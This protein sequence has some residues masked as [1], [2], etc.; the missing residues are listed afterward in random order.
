MDGDYLWF[1][2]TFGLFRY[3]K[4]TGYYDH[5]NEKNGISI[6]AINEEGIVISDSKVFVGTSQGVDFM[7]IDDYDYQITKTPRMLSYNLNGEVV[8][9]NSTPEKIPFNSLFEVNF[10]SLSYPADLIYYSYRLLPDDSIW[11]KPSQNQQLQFINLSQGNY[12]LEIRA[13][14]LGKYN[15]SESASFNFTVEPSFFNTTWFYLL[16]III[17]LVLVLITRAITSFIL[18]KRQKIL[19]TLVA[20]RTKELN[21]YKDNLEVLV[22][23]RTQELEETLDTLK[24]TQNQLIQTEKMASLG[25]L[26][27]GVAHE[28]NNPINYV[29]AGLYS[30]DSIVNDYDSFQSK[31]EM[32]KL[33]KEVL[34]NM[35][36]GVERIIGIVSSLSRFSRGEAEEKSGCSVNLIL[37]NCLMIL[38]HRIKYNIKVK[39]NYVS[40]GPIVSGNESSLHQLFINLLTNAVDAVKHGEEGLISI[41]TKIKNGKVEISIED[42][43]V[44]IDQSNFKNLFDPFYTT[45]SPGAGTGLGLFIA[46]KIVE[47]H[48]GEIKFL[49]EVGK[50]T[51]VLIIFNLSEGEK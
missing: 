11:S 9:K 43:G 49:S 38:D 50:G 8:R 15:W 44:G 28:I 47:D 14:K 46:H 2:N 22:K 32:Q 42:N 1:G 16:L 18:R 24:N 35:N 33:L 6:N 36:F 51:T 48:D 30:I 10:A 40:P 31:D 5:F 19:K 29:K 25:I 45:K 27:A 41:E 20:E 13:K 34:E 21:N 37:D 3:N 4:Q 39:K 17:L 12:T 7:S 26:T 23:N